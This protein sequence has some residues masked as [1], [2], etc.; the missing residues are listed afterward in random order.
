MPHELMYSHLKELRRASSTIAY[1]GTEEHCNMMMISWFKTF[2][3]K[4]DTVREIKFFGFSRSN[5]GKFAIDVN[6]R[7]VVMIG[8]ANFI[9]ETQWNDHQPEITMINKWDSHEDKLY[10][11]FMNTFP[12]INERM[13]GHD[14]KRMIDYVKD[15]YKLAA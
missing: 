11:A 10:T 3:L 2:G 12:A 9:L 7:I 1:I 6:H 13:S 8:F 4:D 15:R 5:K 14:L